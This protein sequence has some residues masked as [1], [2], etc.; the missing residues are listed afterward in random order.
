VDL[1]FVA[2]H[3]DYYP[4]HGFAPAGK[5]DFETHHPIPEK[6]AD[7]W[8]VQALCQDVICSVSGKVICC[9][10]LNKPQL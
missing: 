9:D 3:P 7:A 4:R 5:L 1:V 10:G 8:M 2:G 6:H